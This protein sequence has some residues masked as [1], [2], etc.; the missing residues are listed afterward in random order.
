M[1]KTTVERA[2][3]LARHGGY[4]RVVDLKIQLKREGY[5]G[6]DAH[7]QGALSKQL[8]EICRE[9]VPRGG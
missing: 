8:A 5:N 1:T 3:E 9:K 4:A 2:F 6:I 7:I